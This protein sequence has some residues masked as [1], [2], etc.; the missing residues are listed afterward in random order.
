MS[1][2]KQHVD[3]FLFVTAL[4]A[5]LG[6]LGLLFHTTGLARG[7]GVLWPLL[8]IAGGALLL[9]FSAIKGRSSTSFFAGAF[10]ATIFG[11]AWLLSTLLGWSFAQSWPLIMI[12]AG[13]AWLVAGFRR[14]RRAKAGYI[15]PSSSFILL[16]TLFCLFSFDIVDM[17]LG[18]F[19][20]VWW[21]SFL[22]LGGVVLFIA[23]GA[24]R[25]TG[26]DGVAGSTGAD[27]ADGA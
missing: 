25:K 26:Q 4:V 27:G 19:V 14:N 6:G 23:Y 22:I 15:V 11:L 8:L 13:I 1:G 5:I 12:S 17:S 7:L 16:G 10:F 21:P 20:R 18:A 2:R 3:E 24:A 9:F